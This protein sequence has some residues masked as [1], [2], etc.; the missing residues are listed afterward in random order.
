MGYQLFRDGQPISWRM[1]NVPPAYDAETDTLVEAPTQ[2]DALDQ[3]DPTG[4]LRQ[5]AEGAEM[6]LDDPLVVARAKDIQQGGTANVDWEQ[7]RQEVDDQYAAAI[8]AGFD[9][10]LG[11]SLKLGEE[12]QRLLFDYQQRL[13]RQLSKDPPEVDLTDIKLVKGTDEAWHLATVEQVIGIIDNGAGY[14]ESLNGA[15]AGYEAML[16]AG[17]VDF[18]VEF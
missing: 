12:D 13:L 8:V 11:F 1:T 4:L 2:A 6:R 7:K 17:V 14:V 10:G 3:I 9:T 16:A 18:D 15:Y 5:Y